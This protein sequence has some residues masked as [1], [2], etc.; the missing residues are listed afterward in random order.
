M[1]CTSLEVEGENIFTLARFTLTH[2]ENAVTCM[3]AVQHHRAGVRSW[4]SSMEPLK[5]QIFITS[6]IKIFFNSPWIFVHL[7]C[8]VR[9]VLQIILRQM[10]LTRF[11][12]LTWSCWT[13]WWNLWQLLWRRPRPRLV[14]IIQTIY[15]VVIECR[16]CRCSCSWWWRLSTRGIRRRL[17]IGSTGRDERSVRLRKIWRCRLVE[18]WIRGLLR[19][20]CCLHAVADRRYPALHVHRIFRFDEILAAAICL[21]DK[22]VFLVW[23]FERRRFTCLVN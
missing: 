20:G 18:Y 15:I 12:E 9:V 22:R 2:E 23:H 14:I 8:Q 3:S 13:P 4:E 7:C 6:Y 5:C 21:Q 16:G 1:L 10:E 17:R 19:G 11:L